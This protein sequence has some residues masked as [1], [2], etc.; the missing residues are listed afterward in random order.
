MKR[1][2]RIADLYLA[3]QHCFVL[4]SDEGLSFVESENP[5]EDIK[6]YMLEGNSKYMCAVC[7]KNMLL[8]DKKVYVNHE[9]EDCPVCKSKG[10]SSFS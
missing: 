9:N 1:I 2:N 10:K 4:E 8:T 6:K 7:K 5:L 3:K